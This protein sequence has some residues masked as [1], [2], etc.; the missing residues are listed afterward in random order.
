MRCDMI[1]ELLTIPAFLKR[2]KKRG[3]PRKIIETPDVNILDKY[4]EWDKIKQDK[5]GTRYA[6]MFKDEAPRIGSGLRFVYTKEKR[7]WAF[8]TK[9]TGDPE[10]TSRKV[11]VRMR[12]KRWQEIKEN[13]VLYFKR[14][15]ADEV[16][17]RLSR[18]RYRRVSKNT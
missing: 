15:S 17:K 6:I 16:K 10:D 9:H 18:K 7:K 2:Q 13:S 4:F 1:N 14:N 5:Y 11:T 3:R 12:L 8:V